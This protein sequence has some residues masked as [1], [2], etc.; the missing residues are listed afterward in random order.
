MI[1][2][3]PH[4]KLNPWTIAY[5]ALDPKWR[6]SIGQLSERLALDE[7]LSTLVKEGEIQNDYNT[8]IHGELDG[9]KE[10]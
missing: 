4:R 9:E 3:A 2:Y 5:D 8:Y 7:E 6:S 10:N 1:R